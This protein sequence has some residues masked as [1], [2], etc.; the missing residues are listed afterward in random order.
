M[1][2]DYLQ[3]R[4]EAE[5]VRIDEE[6]F[7]TV[8]GAETKHGLAIKRLSVRAR[9]E[10][11]DKFDIP[12]NRIKVSIT[13]PWVSLGVTSKILGKDSPE[14]ISRETISDCLENLVKHG[15]LLDID[16]KSIRTEAS[17]T[18]AEATK[19][20]VHSHL[21]SNKDYET[22]SRAV[23]NPYRWNPKIWDHGFGLRKQVKE[24][25]EF[26][27]IYNKAQE[28]KLE[29]MRGFMGRHL[30]DNPYKNEKSIRAEARLLSSKSVRKH[31]GGN[32]VNDLL[33]HEDN[34]LQEVFKKAFIKPETIINRK[35]DKVSKKNISFAESLDYNTKSITEAISSRDKHNRARSYRDVMKA[36][37]TYDKANIESLENLNELLN[38]L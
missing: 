23:F 11:K 29:R 26:L 9:N 19:D 1:K 37:M 24:D 32:K 6:K 15:V 34:A 16:S 7:D 33:E 18:V 36:L 5:Y 35:S 10:I 28:V 20:Y 14:L 4:T 3:L 27:S 13:G 8:P 17:V 25:K 22:F 21:L 38:N 12:T 30:P 31:F 2:F